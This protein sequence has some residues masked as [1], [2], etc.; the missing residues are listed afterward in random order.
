MP[1]T[2]SYS[3]DEINIGDGKGTLHLR[4]AERINNPIVEIVKRCG[5]P[6]IPKLCDYGCEC[7][8]ICKQFRRYGWEDSEAGKGFKVTFD[9]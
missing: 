4:E 6:Y 9:E 1:H 2:H 7:H 8:E 5:N 3:E